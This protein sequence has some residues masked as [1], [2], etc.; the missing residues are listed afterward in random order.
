M[1]TDNKLYI[2]W[3]EKKN[4]TVCCDMTL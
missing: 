4:V 2:P 1:A 3:M